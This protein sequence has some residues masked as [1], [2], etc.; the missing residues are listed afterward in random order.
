[1]ETPCPWHL[2]IQQM[3]LTLKQSSSQPPILWMCHHLVEKERSITIY[4]N[5]RPFYKVIYA[6]RLLSLYHGLIRYSHLESSQSS[7][8]ATT[9]SMVPLDIKLSPMFW[10]NQ[11]CVHAF[12]F[13]FLLKSKAIETMYML[14]HEL[15]II[16]AC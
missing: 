10:S 13:L 4:N 2:A 12:S 9:K 16:T 7:K 1:M 5:R 6:Y 3:T 15:R 11:S 8:Q 14:N